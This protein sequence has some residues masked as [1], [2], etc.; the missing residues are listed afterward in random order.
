MTTRNAD[1]PL[2][3]ALEYHDDSGVLPDTLRVG[4]PKGLHDITDIRQIDVDIDAQLR[5]AATLHQKGAAPPATD[6][7]YGWAGADLD[8]DGTLWIHYL[9]P[10][11]DQHP[12]T[13]R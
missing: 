13:T 5:V 1:A 2:K 8:E 11:P 9:A 10:R 12:A 3:V 4:L 6:P 7:L